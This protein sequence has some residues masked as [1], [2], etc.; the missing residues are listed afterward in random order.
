[1]PSI[2]CFS[3]ARVAHCGNRSFESETQRRPVGKLAYRSF[4]DANNS[5][6]AAATAH[7]IFSAT[8]GSW[9]GITNTQEPVR[10]CL[11]S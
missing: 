5:K 3:I 8:R 4:A 10:I 7:A 1:M 6:L 9:Q 11:P 2:S